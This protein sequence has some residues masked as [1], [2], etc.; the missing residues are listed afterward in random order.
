[1]TEKKQISNVTVPERRGGTSTCTE[2]LTISNFEELFEYS[3]YNLSKLFEYSG[4]NLSSLKILTLS[5]LIELRVIWSG[6]IQ[7]EHFQNLTQLTVNDCRRLRY[8]FSPT[9]ARN[10]PQLL[11]LHIWNCEELEQIIEKDQ[12]PSQHHLQPIC[13]PNLGWIRIFNCK[14]LKCLFPITL[15]HGGLPNL[16]GLGLTR[17]SK[18]EQVFEGD[19][20]NLNKEEEKVI[21]LP[22]LR[23]LKLVELPNLVSFSP[24]G[25]HFVFPSLTD[26]R[27]EGCPNLTTRF[28]VDSEKSVHAKT[29]ELEFWE[30]TEKKQISNVTVPE[31]RG[32]TSTCTEYL[33][34][35]NFEDGPIQVEHFQNLTH[36]AVNDCRRLRYIFSP[37]I[38][39]NLPQLSELYIWDCEEW[40]QIIEKDQTSSQHHLQPI[41]FPNLGWIRIFNCKNL[42][43][44][45]P[46]TL[47]HGG[48]PNLC[49]LGLTRVSKLEQVFEGD[50]TNLNME[51]EKVI[52]LPQLRS[53]E[54][55]EL[56]NLVSFSPRLEVKGCPNITTR[57]SVDSKRSVHAKTQVHYPSKLNYKL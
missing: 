3:G 7:V 8:I 10:L 1:M 50:E 25:Y 21:R 46:I 41:C 9:I 23:S 18:L 45:F 27:V 43:C 31:R 32:G 5:K 34:I 42:K 33:T 22:L 47:A 13:F 38:A 40:E 37:T 20:T 57:F 15:A 51:E 48:L 14:N 11:E 53:L 49:G 4:Y 30:M 29:Q 52:R 28:S 35:S 12:T 6:P 2:Y 36:L 54:L 26:L 19:E 55:Y 16:C 56:P 17:V 24:V 39:R 44:L